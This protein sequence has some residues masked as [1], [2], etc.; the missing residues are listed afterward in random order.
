MPE[1]IEPITRSVPEVYALAFIELA[2]KAEQLDAVGEELNE[3]TALLGEQPDIMRLL[4]N[5]I[6]ST[7]QR[8][9]SIQKIFKD[10]ISDLTYRF[11]QVVNQ[12]ERLDLLPEI[13]KSFGQ[14]VDQRQGTVEVDAYVASELD[15]ERLEDLAA[16]IGIAIDKNVV[17]NQ[18]VD[19]SLIGGLKLRVGDRLIDGSV[20]TQLQIMKRKMIAEGREKAKTQLSQLIEENA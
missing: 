5:R 13:I 16:K 7:D 9:D 6:L 3:L 18:I 14:F 2:E 17:L 8:A 19:E 15:A 20:A 4:S 12:K 10:N 1:H 11:L